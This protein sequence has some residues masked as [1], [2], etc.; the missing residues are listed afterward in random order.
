MAICGK[1][2]NEAQGARFCPT[3]GAEV[4][5]QPAPPPQQAAPNYQQPPAPNA[6]PG[7]FEDTFRNL[8]NTPDQTSQF[9]PADI[10]QN[11]VMAVLAYFG[12]LVLIPILAAPNSRFARYHANQGLVLCIAS[13][14]L[15]IV[16]TVVST[17]V[18]AISWRLGIISTLLSL[19]YILPLV[20]IIL[21]IVNAATGK[22][23]ELP[24][25]GKIK[26]LK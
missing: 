6:Q 13:I 25:I 16:M 1:C 15:A 26:I 14:L 7:G 20:L 5:A 3:C 9:D 18:L 11:K 19:V 10:A 23:K 4:G 2:G 12:I 22:A 8:N 17:I 21:G 24:L